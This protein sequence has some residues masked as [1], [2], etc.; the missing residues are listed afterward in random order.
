MRVLTIAAL[1]VA[2]CFCASAHARIAEPVHGGTPCV[3]ACKE[4]WRVCFRNV[5]YSTPGYKN[6]PGAKRAAVEAMARQQCSAEWSRFEAC[7]R[8]CDKSA[9]HPFTTASR[10]KL[11]E[12]VLA[13]NR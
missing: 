4:P 13:C 6:A 11:A 8:R 5:C 1:V 2:F 3:N 10:M 9:A 7:K 12:A